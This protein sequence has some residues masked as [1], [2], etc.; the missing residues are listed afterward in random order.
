MVPG[1]TRTP[2]EVTTGTPFCH[3]VVFS[4]LPGFLINAPTS[5]TSG[6][7]P[8]PAPARPSEDFSSE[9]RA[10]PVSSKPLTRVPAVSICSSTGRP[11]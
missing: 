7:M 5:A 1:P 4:W 8:S 11:S 9:R 10:S 3:S 2:S 6:T